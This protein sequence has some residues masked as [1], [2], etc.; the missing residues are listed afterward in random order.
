M[1]NITFTNKL[2]VTGIEPIC[3][4]CW[5]CRRVIPKL[6]GGYVSAEA[7]RRGVHL[8][9]HYCVD[10]TSGRSHERVDF[11]KPCEHFNYN[12]YNQ[13]ER[14][15]KSGKLRTREELIKIFMAKR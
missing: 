10:I 12:P 5:A 14:H 13:F 8:V 2:T 15:S 4:M 11:K 6:P 1:S 9:K 3:Q 7:R